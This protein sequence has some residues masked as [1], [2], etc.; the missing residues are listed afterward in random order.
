MKPLSSLFFF[1]ESVMILIGIIIGAGVF[2][3]PYLGIFSGLTFTLFWLIL[4]FFIICYLHLAFGEIIL[5]TGKEHRLVGYVSYYLGKNAKILISLTTFFTFSFSLLIYLL[6]GARFLTNILELYFSSPYLFYLV[7]FFLWLFLNFITLFAS[8]HKISTVNLLFSFLIFIVF[9][10]I[11][12]MYLSSFKI[13]NLVLL[14]EKTNSLNYFLKFFLPYGVIFFALNGAVGIPELIKNFKKRNLPLASIKKAI[15]LGTLLPMLFYLLFIFF[16]DGIC[17]KY[18][19]G[20]ALTCLKDHLGPSA[21]F[22]GNIIGFL[23]VTTSYIIFTLYL[24]NTFLK[25]FQFPASLTQMII[26]LGPILFYL[27]NLKNTASLASFLG[28][29]VGGMEGLMILFILK[30][31]KENEQISSPYSLKFN[32]FIFYFFLIILILGALMQ[33][34]I[35]PLAL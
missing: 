33:T 35:V 6:L 11:I 23:A 34:F 31:V 7:L 3:L 8:F 16:V 19:T 32:S 18:V 27:L 15:I 5:K 24:K 10:F 25:D 17:G 2:A 9:L 29:L 4:S 13:Q 22:L 21:I 1:L 20:D 26:S 12:F 30:K 28:G 14:P